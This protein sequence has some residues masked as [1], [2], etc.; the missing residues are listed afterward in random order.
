MVKC[1]IR[2]K[3]NLCLF[4]LESKTKHFED[5]GSER[6]SHA[7]DPNITLRLS[8]FDDRHLR[9]KTRVE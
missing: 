9:E 3:G 4:G 1:G 6:I 5:V 8:V 2:S 7:A